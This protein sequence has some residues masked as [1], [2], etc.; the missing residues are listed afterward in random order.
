LT[1]IHHFLAFKTFFDLGTGGRRSA[2]E[3]DDILQWRS[4]AAVVM[5]G[6]QRQS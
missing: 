1:A 6:E 5:D 3:T 4:A 2:V